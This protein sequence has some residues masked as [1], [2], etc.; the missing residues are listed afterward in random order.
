MSTVAIIAIENANK[1]IDSIV[2]TSDGYIEH[3][4]ELLPQKYNT[5]QR[6]E[7]LISHGSISVLGPEI[8]KKHDFNAPREGWT[9]HSDYKKQTPI[10][11]EWC[12]FHHRDRGDDLEIDQYEDENHLLTTYGKDSWAEFVY[13]YKDRKWYVQQNNI[14]NYSILSEQIDYIKED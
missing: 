7:Y 1:S 13:I 12:R 2:C 14:D 10:P 5:K 8:G 6:I 3:T 9:W 11:K 4:G